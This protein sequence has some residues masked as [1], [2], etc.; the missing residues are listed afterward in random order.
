M[1]NPTLF[2]HEIKPG[3]ANDVKAFVKGCT[4]GKY[5]AYHD[6][7]K[8]YDLNDTCW[9]IHELDG[10]FYLL[11]THNMGTNGF[12]NL[13]NWNK[14]NDPFEGWFDSQLKE[15]FVENHSN[16]QPEYIDTIQVT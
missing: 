3:K 4:H 6:L 12:K 7:L 1:K 10:K 11:F 13:E 2:C 14:D 9:W 5:E 16:H 8:K 15:F